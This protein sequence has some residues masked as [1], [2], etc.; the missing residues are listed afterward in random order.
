MNS[1]RG[2]VIG[3]IEN[4]LDSPQPVI[5]LDLKPSSKLS[6]NVCQIFIVSKSKLSPMS[7]ITQC[8]HVMLPSTLDSRQLIL[9]SDGA[10]CYYN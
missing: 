6:T 3:L 7:H 2:D 5:N 10:I 1:L 9:D 8:H 4:K